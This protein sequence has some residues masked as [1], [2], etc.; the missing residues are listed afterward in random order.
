MIPSTSAREQLAAEA[1]TD[2]L[3]VVRTSLPAKTLD[4][5]ETVRSYKSLAPG[6]ARVSLPQDGRSECAAGLP[7]AGGPGAGACTSVHAGL[8]SGM[9]HAPVPGANAV[10]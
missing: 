7:L 1:A 9:A 10:R 2:G 6:G 4:D 3:Y 5:A 8:L